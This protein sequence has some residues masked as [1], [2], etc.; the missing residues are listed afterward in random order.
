MVVVS[1][2][3]F[4]V[5]E[6]D[7]RSFFA[8]PVG[9]VKRVFVLRTGALIFN[10]ALI[11]FHK[12]SHVQKAISLA[13]QGMAFGGEFDIIIQSAE[14]FLQGKKPL[15]PGSKAHGGGGGAHTEGGGKGGNKCKVQ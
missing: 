1:E 8:G 15:K 14:D 6:E 7:I 3:P 10:S 12:K 5:D 13:M 4:V 11:E 2:L 9:T